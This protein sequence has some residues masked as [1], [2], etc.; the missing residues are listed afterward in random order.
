MIN[1]IHQGQALFEIISDGFVRRHKF[2]RIFPL[3]EIAIIFTLT[4]ISED[5]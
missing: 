2:L 5:S 4:Y 3:E 1:E